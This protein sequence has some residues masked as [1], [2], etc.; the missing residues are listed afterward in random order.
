MFESVIGLEIHAQLATQSK[1]FCSCPTNTNA[2]P[3]NNTCP[4]CLGLPGAL[5]TTNRK[6]V[7][8]AIMLGL[9]TNCK[10]RLI[11][12]F[13]RKNYFY[14]DLPKAY[15]ISQYEK[16]ICEDGFIKI[17][18]EGQTKKINI[19]RI[20]LEEDAGKL[21]HKKIDYSLIDLNRAGVP[22]VEIVSEPDLRTPEEAK[23]YMQKIHSIVTS[24]DVC[25]GDMEKG[26]L[27]C[28][29]NISLR[30]KG[31]KKFG[32]RTE[33]KNLNSFRFIEQAIEYE[34]DRQTDLLLDGEAISQETRLFDSIKKKTFLMRKKEES[35]DYRY[36][37][38][39]DLPLVK[40]SQEWVEKIKK[41]LPELP[42]EKIKRYKRDY[43]LN[44]YDASSIVLN[45]FADF[46][47]KTIS[48]GT[49]TKQIVNW[50]MSDISKYLNNKK[51]TLPQTCLTPKK[52]ASLL[53]LIKKGVINNKIAKRVL[54]DI[55]EQKKTAQQIV[56]KHNL[57]Q[58]SDTKMLEKLC[59]DIITKNPEEVE[60]YQ[61]GKDRVFG[62]FVGQIMKETK[63]KANPQLVSKYL[64]QFL[65]NKV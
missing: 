26:N 16:P 52:L 28:D 14:P 39:P 64:Q 54:V 57:A 55:I 17:N 36:F 15:Q 47:E 42:D 65:K 48:T 40:I 10:I 27:R 35:D 8:F 41:K 46:F 49:D 30:K 61:Q 22:L 43:K 1:L 31:E 62:F 9:A 13:A 37:P 56:E 44:D 34:I 60:K 38:C 7:E 4:I 12:E 5:P 50:L 18:V 32:I 6:A 59:K 53:A 25:S 51:K 58:V 33:T 23:L 29:A 24:L 20:H 11:S 45:R 2:N 3:N 19:T 21:L 63:G